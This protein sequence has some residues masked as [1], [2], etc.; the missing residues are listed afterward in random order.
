MLFEKGL[1]VKRDP[2]LAFTYYFLAARLGPRQMKWESMN[3]MAKE[4][5]AESMNKAERVAL[6]WKLGKPL[7]G[8]NE[9]SASPAGRE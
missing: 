1:H 6:E 2:A 3:R 4:L 7:P 5:P 9:A 8:L